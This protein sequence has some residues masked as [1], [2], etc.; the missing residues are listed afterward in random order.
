[1]FKK[2]II[3][4]VL[5]LIASSIWLH[6]ENQELTVQVYDLQKKDELRGLTKEDKLMKAISDSDLVAFSELISVINTNYSTDDGMTFLHT[7]VGGNQLDMARELIKAGADVNAVASEGLSI[8]HVAVYL[9]D[10]SMMELLLKESNKPNVNV[11]DI[12]GFTPLQLAKNDNNEVITQL[13]IDAG[14]TE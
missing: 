7:A 11:K 13:L 5:C 14:A 10:E 6:Y 8:F 12:N 4:A 3:I 9:G 1:M 2:L